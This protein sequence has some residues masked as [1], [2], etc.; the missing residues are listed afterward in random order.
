MVAEKYKSSHELCAHMFTKFYVILF[1]LFFLRYQNTIETICVRMCKLKYLLLN[2]KNWKPWQ[3]WVEYFLCKFLCV[4][5]QFFFCVCFLL[6]FRKMKLIFQL[7]LLWQ[8]IDRTLINRTF[9]FFSY[10]LKT[11]NESLKAKKNIQF[12]PTSTTTA[13]LTAYFEFY[14][15]FWW[16]NKLQPKVYINL[17]LHF[18]SS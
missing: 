16:F 2:W 8:Q 11:V 6:V 14:C 7:C 15:K 4:I 12:P 13:A 10:K 1:R 5:S 17:Y 3:P 9:F 18:K